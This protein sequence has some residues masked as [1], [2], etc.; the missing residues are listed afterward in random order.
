MLF[1]THPVTVKVSPASAVAAAHQPGH[2]DHQ[3]NAEVE[4]RPPAKV[5]CRRVL[6]STFSAPVFEALPPGCCCGYGAVARR[7]WQILFQ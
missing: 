3:Q 2:A 4:A 7:C 6:S 5:S 1:S